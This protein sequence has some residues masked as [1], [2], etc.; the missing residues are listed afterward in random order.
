MVRVLFIRHGKTEW[1]LN[2]KIQ[3]RRDIPL[4]AEGI[5]EIERRHIPEEFSGFCWASSPLTR[6]VETARLLGAADITLTDA[7]IE[8]DW[9]LWEGCRVPNLRKKYGQEMSRNE[10]RGLHM[11]P[12]G[13]E[14]PSEVVNRVQFWLQS[15]KRDT[16]AVTHK[17][18]I[19]AIKSLAYNWDMTDKA[20]VKFDWNCAHLFDVE[21]CGRIVANRV[22]ISLGKE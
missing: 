22:N 11:R 10:A 20:P 3:G 8:M 12:E 9:G 17:G 15:L 2:K 21:L 16:I 6:A 7:L 14:S 1:N 4:C 18:V 5:K 13:G 19:R